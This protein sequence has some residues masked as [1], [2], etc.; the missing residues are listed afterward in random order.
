M[1]ETMFKTTVPKSDYVFDVPLFTS[2][3][4]IHPLPFLGRPPRRAAMKDSAGAPGKP[5]ERCPQA[6]LDSPFKADRLYWNH[7]TDGRRVTGS[8]FLNHHPRKAR[9]RKGERLCSIP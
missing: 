8:T 5:L 9:R 3:A 2:P 4:A 6:T 7:G 1:L